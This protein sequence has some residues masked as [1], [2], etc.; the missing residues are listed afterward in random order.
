[1]K[2]SVIIPVYNVEA[3]LAA[4]LESVLM[5]T[6]KNIEIIL[7]NDGSTDS[8][9]EICREF[10]VKHPEII[11]LSQ[12]N[13]GLSA[14]RNRGLDL[15]RGE[16][17]LFLD[18]DDT[19]S[20]DAI[21]IFAKAVSESPADIVIPDHVFAVNSAGKS[22]VYRDIRLNP[23]VELTGLEYLSCCMRGNAYNA[24][25]QFCLY[26][27]RFLEQNKIRF[28][29][30]IY[31]ED[32]LFTPA[33]MISAAKVRV[34][35]NPFYFYRLRSGSITGSP[36]NQKRVNDL[37]FVL[38]ELASMYD[39]Q[40]EAKDQKILFDYWSRQKMGIAMHQFLLGSI[41]ETERKE[42][43]LKT[44][45]PRISRP[46]TWVKFL[47][48]TYLPGLYLFLNPSLKARHA[49]RLKEPSR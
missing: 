49:L 26:N 2:F 6:E 15:A 34:I 36:I 5:Q 45:K 47:L 8:G 44:V 14:T 31:H 37:V 17:V 32:E 25:S 4:C 29:E 40:I 12:N 18:S 24:A 21:A 33:V 13:R 42:I 9:G 22:K 23:P 16:Y 39:R 20:R 41:T 35:R 19:I 27:R 3:Y 38:N 10:A 48:F 46:A 43:A 28:V 7:I 30:G 11:Y 1:M